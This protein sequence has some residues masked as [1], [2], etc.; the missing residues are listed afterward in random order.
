[1]TGR[2]PAYEELEQRVKKLEREASAQ[3]QAEGLYHALVE[4]SLQ[5]LIII[6][7]LLI[8]FANNAFAEL[9]GYTVEELL[10]L[11]PESVMA[12][13]YPEDRT[14]VWGRLQDRLQGKPV[15]CRYEFRGIRKDGNMRW[16]EMIA[17]KIDYNGAPA[18][19]G[20]FIDI[21]ERKGAEEKLR[22]QKTRLESL[23]NYSSLAIVALDEKHAIV[24]CNRYFEDLFQ[25]KESEIMGKNLDHV[26]AKGQC[27]RDAVSYTRKTLGGEPI[28]GSGK[29]YRKDGTRID[30]EFFGVPVRV[31]G[32]EVG[33]YGIYMDISERKQIEKALV[34]E[35]ERFRSL[36]ENAPFGMVMI[37][38]DGTFTHMNPK[39]YELFG[40][41]LSDIPNGRTWFQ[42]AYPDSD[43][44]HKAISAW[45]E[46]LASSEIG[47]K[48]PRV[49]EVQCKDGSKKIINF[50]PVQLETGENLMACEDITDIKRAEEALKESEEKYRLLV[51]NATEAIF[52]A[53]DEVVKFPNPKTE[54]MVAYTKKELATIPFADLI[55]PDDRAMVLERDRTRLQGEK[56]PSSYSFRVIRKSGD[57]AWVHLNAVATTWEGRP[58]T[59]NFLR[60]ITE[61]R[62]LE[63]QLHHA[64]RMEALGTLA[65]GIAHD[66]NNL[67]MGIQGN[68]SLMLF[69][70]D[71]GHPDYDGLRNIERYVQDGA[72][73]TKQLLGFARGGR[74]NVKPSDLNKIV[75]RS[76]DMF[77]KTKKEITIHTKYQ[78]DIWASEVDQAQIEQ[79]LLNLYVNAWQAMPAGG[80][81]YLKTQNVTLDEDYVK[82]Y[83]MK[84]GRFV[85]I[86]ITDTGV[87]MDKKTK[88]RIFEPFFTTKEMGRG[89]G[90]GLASV[91]GII[92]NHAGII[93]VYSEKGEGTTFTLY[94][95]ATEKK[96]MEG[97]EL[98]KDIQKGTETILLV[99]DEDMILTIGEKLLQSFGYTVITARSGKEA[100]ETL[101]AI[102]PSSPPDLVIL[103]MIMP[104]MTGG[105]TYD[106]MKEIHPAIKVLLSSGYS[107]NG[108]AEKILKRG[109]NGFI[110]KPFTMRE[111]SQSVRHILEKE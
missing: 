63:S 46:D 104:Q 100:I 32:N 105:E 51:E 14:L 94:L 99:D 13:I 31:D 21:S 7:D 25:F 102:L 4:K 27:L 85:K 97:K 76:S 44:R 6:Q 95:P 20:A 101:K 77:G 80:E 84:P 8:V 92:K 79:A 93:N 58:A 90:L 89:T 17:S 11:S 87:G 52:I 33:A 16:L 34:A 68:A 64:Q 110:Q 47:E 41:D 71:R 96:P 103:D 98:S 26:I 70:K 65:R 43:H 56:A 22:L 23:I 38:K 107:I 49:F 66:F 91:Y 28:H 42:K 60:D 36:A 39:F 62:R 12:L 111:L 30:V 61:Q 59:L 37:D 78:Q 2:R 108:Q 35:K 72:D 109:C 81:L 69:D 86:A 24:S 82:R 54:E 50:I 73:L 10:S 45:I 75:R 40:Y 53:Q 88:Q 74:Y 67:L 9:S 106:R 18:I 3:K 19:Q 83:N 48:R 15:P 29:R 1:M 55:H 57:E 5:G